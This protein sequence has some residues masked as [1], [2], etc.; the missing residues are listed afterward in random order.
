MHTGRTIM[1]IM[2]IHVNNNNI[3]CGRREARVPHLSMS[4]KVIH[5][6]QGTFP[7]KRMLPR[8]SCTPRA[9][10]LKP[11]QEKPSM[12]PIVTPFADEETEA[13]REVTCPWHPAG[14]D[15]AKEGTASL[16]QQESRVPRTLEAGW[17]R[18][19]SEP[20]FCPLFAG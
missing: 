7:T 18:P 2:I 17:V 1:M 9:T 19:R 12:V 10:N 3:E 11:L 6:T 13:Q 20:R 16:P 4:Q 14:N 8:L 15:R 5:W